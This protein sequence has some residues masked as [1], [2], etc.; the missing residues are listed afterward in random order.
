MSEIDLI[1]LP[2]E[3]WREILASASVL[4]LV[5]GGYT[6]ARQREVLFY[7]GPDNAPEGW[8]GGYPEGSPEHPRAAVGAAEVVHYEEAND[9]FTIRLT[10]SNWSAARDVNRAFARGEYGERFQDFVLDQEAALRGGPAERR[11]L[12]EQF[13]RLRRHSA[14]GLLDEP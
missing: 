8:S 3:E 5:H 13:Q 4:D 11:W 6:R 12:R 7:C 1:E 10:V 2:G 9:Q 14:G